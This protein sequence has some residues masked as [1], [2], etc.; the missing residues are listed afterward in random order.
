MCVCCSK[1]RQRKLAV[2]VNVYLA[3]EA[4][5]TKTC[6]PRIQRLRTKEQGSTVGYAELQ[7]TILILKNLSKRSSARTLQTPNPRLKKKQQQHRGGM[8][9]GA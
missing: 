3:I 1:Q 2:L 4:I 7:G 9:R 5:G 8:W 6:I